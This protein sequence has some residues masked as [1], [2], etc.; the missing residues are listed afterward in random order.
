M[1]C[2]HKHLLSLKSKDYKA[3]IKEWNL[4]KG[5][6]TAA[7]VIL[8]R[9]GMKRPHFPRE[10]IALQH[11]CHLCS[12]HCRAEHCNSLFHYKVPFVPYKQS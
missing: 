1:L 8:K 3:F 11:D 12:L 6:F 10:L 4:N 9:K 2:N 7:F 5:T